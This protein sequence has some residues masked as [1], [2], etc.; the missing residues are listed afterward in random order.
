[1]YPLCVPILGC[2]FLWFRV[3][4]PD[5]F[6]VPVGNKKEKKKNAFEFLF[7]VVGGKKREA[8]R[9]EQKGPSRISQERV[10]EK[11]YREEKSIKQDIFVRRKKKIREISFLHV[12]VLVGNPFMS[13]FTRS[14]PSLLE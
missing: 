8:A 3:P 13:S 4:G 7:S 12:F 10:P 6:P 5:V 9:T 11:K 2:S 14:V 1:V